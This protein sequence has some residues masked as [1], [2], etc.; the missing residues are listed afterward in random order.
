[1]AHDVFISYSIKDRL[2]ADALCHTLEEDRLRCWIAPRDISPGGSWAGEIAE[3][4]PKSKIMIL[5]FSSNSNASKQVLREVEL[6]ISSDIAIIPMKIED[7]MPTGGMKY[8][9]STTHWIDAVGVKFENRATS[10]SKRIQA[11]LAADKEQSK[12]EKSLLHDTKFNES[13]KVKLPQKGKEKSRKNKKLLYV[14]IPIVLVVL[15]VLGYLAITY[16]FDDLNFNNLSESSPP[17]ATS[18]KT[19]DPMQQYSVNVGKYD[20]QNY[21]PEDFHYNSEK[22][23]LFESEDLRE[24]ISN[25]LVSTSGRSDGEES[26]TIGN[27]FELPYLILRNENDEHTENIIDFF[28][29]IMGFEF[30][31]F[32]L[33]SP[34]SLSSLNGLQYARNMLFLEIDGYT[35]ND[36]SPL[37]SLTSLLHLQLNLDSISDIS[38]MENLENL[39][40]LILS[41]IDTEDLSG[42]E[43][44]THLESLSLESH[45]GLSPDFSPIGNLEFLF[46]LNINGFSA[47]EI[48]A[49]ENLKQI[50]NLDLAHLGLSDISSI[51]NMLS[52]ENLVLSY[53][54]ISDISPLL[55]LYNL[56]TLSLTGNPKVSLIGLEKI[57]TLQELYID[58]ETYNNNLETVNKL[59]N[60]GCI[61]YNEGVVTHSPEHYDLNPDEIVVFED[62][63]LEIQLKV[64]FEEM[65]T[66]VFEDITIRDMFNITALSLYPK[67]TEDYVDIISEYNPDIPILIVNP[68]DLTSLEGLQYAKN[69]RALSL[70]DYPTPDIN[71][72]S[73]FPNLKTL[74]IINS[75]IPDLE[76][77]S[78]L[79]NLEQ[80]I[81]HHNKILEIDKISG[82]SNLTDLN[83]A[84]NPDINLSGL[85][86]LSGLTVLNLSDNNLSD[87]TVLNNLK[88]LNTLYL[89]NNPVDN[90]SVLESL[91][92][93]KQLWID[94]TLYDNNMD[95]INKLI[96]N[97]CSVIKSS[98]T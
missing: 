9:L 80:L 79:I 88:N 69:L 57:T 2:L 11:M 32:E 5:V 21:Q 28:N 25:T 66:P 34:Y 68:D 17:S 3:A 33:C 86:N 12:A 60:N 73:E 50:R 10:L 42:L 27:M 26:I 53:N 81:L 67:T 72:L 35:I 41:N 38:P 65:G 78:V 48:P 98:A 77:L 15:S 63:N 22:E 51:K 45:S 29:E 1:M 16:W 23:V 70:I 64:A 96:N 49:L 87:I 61:V 47:T 55:S 39:L 30:S 83:L 37:S 18:W 7:V 58:S 94:E 40:T 84:Y 54:N 74:I 44:L 43:N 75:E 14:V 95:T 46:N 89:G 62:E 76:P 8:Y 20:I 52:L 93:L 71:P 85:E 90:I 36:L 56:R 82:L 19:R 59:K 91:D 92:N 97:G 31:E 13:E 4:I 24:S 6:A